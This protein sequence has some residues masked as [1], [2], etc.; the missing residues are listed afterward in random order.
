VSDLLKIPADDYTNKGFFPYKRIRRRMA[1]KYGLF[2]L[3][4]ALL[5][6]IVQSLFVLDNL[7]KS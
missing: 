1:K 3:L 5:I 4:I 2:L 7:K 6:V